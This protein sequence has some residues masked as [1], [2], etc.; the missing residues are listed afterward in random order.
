MSSVA[1]L[2]LWGLARSIAVFIVFSFVY[3][4]FGAG[5]V[6]MW[7]RMGTAVSEEPTAALA[8]FSLFCGNVFAGPLSSSLILPVIV[9]G[10]Y[11]VTKYKSVILLSGTCMLCSVVSI[12]AWY[13]RP[14]AIR[15]I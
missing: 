12:G 6:A 11:G 14:K 7:A 13:A 4:F 8:T 2:T 1:S 9:I 15:T 3:G 5:Y 10:S